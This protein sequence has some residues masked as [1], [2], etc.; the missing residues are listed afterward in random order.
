MKATGPA[1]FQVGDKV[2]SHWYAETSPGDEK[3]VRTILEIVEN[4]VRASG[5]AARA[6]G[7]EVCQ[8]CGKSESFPVPP[9]GWPVSKLV[10]SS[11]FNKYEPGNS[12]EV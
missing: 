2:T 12:H 4:T 10:D 5:Y 11:W 9:V 7:G 8:A 6:D 3:I 1:P